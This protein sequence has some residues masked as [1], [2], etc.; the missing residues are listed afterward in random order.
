[1]PAPAQDPFANESLHA[2]VGR[3][4][5]QM[6]VASLMGEYMSRCDVIDENEPLDREAAARRIADLF[7]DTAIWEGVGRSVE[8]F[9]RLVGREAI[10][11]LFRPKAQQPLRFVHNFHFLNTPRIEMRGDMATGHWTLL[12]AVA[13]GDGRRTWRI[14]RNHVDFVCEGNCW[15][16]AHFRAETLHLSERA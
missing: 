4:E 12:C 1:M 5:A 14:A 15:K 9:P 8:E 3:I 2:R 7:T 11:G 6:A 13:Y 16:I 10:R